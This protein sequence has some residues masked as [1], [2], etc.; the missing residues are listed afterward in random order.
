M[1]G[2]EAVGIN[3]GQP[4]H[5]VFGRVKVVRDEQRRCLTFQTTIA[6]PMTHV[7]SYDERVQWVPFTINSETLARPLVNSVIEQ[8]ILLERRN[9]ITHLLQVDPVNIANSSTLVIS[10]STAGSACN[11]VD[12]GVVSVINSPIPNVEFTQNATAVVGLVG[13]AATVPKKR[14]RI[15]PEGND[16]EAEVEHTMGEGPDVMKVDEHNEGFNASVRVIPMQTNPLFV[17]K[18]FRYVLGFDYCFTVNREGRGGGLALFWNSAFNCS[19]SNYSQNHID[20]E[21]VDTSICNWRLRCYNG[22]PGSRQKRAAW[23]FLKHLSQ[24]S[25]LPWCVVGDFNDILSPHEK[26]GRNERAYWLINGFRSAV[27]DSG[28]SDIHMEGYPFTWFK[29]FGTVKAVEE[30]L[31]RALATEN[32]HL[33]FPYAI[34]ENLPAPASDHYPISKFF[35]QQWSSYESLEITQKLNCC[36]SDLS[37]WSKS[38]FHNI[39]REVD[40]SPFVIEEFKEAM[41]SMK[42]DKCPGPDGFNP[43]SFPAS[44]N[45]TNIA[46]IPKGVERSPYIGYV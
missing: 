16:E 9:D 3:A 25:N 11:M 37:H 44:L 20:V 14:V 18:I 42:P 8:R 30:R 2:T 24:S 33:L 22:F 1:T 29:S 28:L 4:V 41:F 45:L 19:I 10:S 43:G 23:N 17:E 13:K 46:L 26:N 40:K 27:L 12:A 34:L 39:R 6:N 31:D 5:A 35:Q 32:W 38:H 15:N 21:I 36:A 7:A